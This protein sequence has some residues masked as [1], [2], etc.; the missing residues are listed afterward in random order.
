MHIGIVLEEG[1]ANC[2]L[3]SDGIIQGNIFLTTVTMELQQLFG[4]R[5]N[6]IPWYILSAGRGEDFEPITRCVTTA[7]KE[8]IEEWGEAIYLKDAI[9]ESD[10]NPL[11]KQICEV[12][13]KQEQNI[14][15]HRHHN[16]FK[17]LGKKD[18]I[19]L[20]ARVLMLDVLTK[21]YHPSNTLDIEMCA[22][23]MRKT[24]EYLFRHANSIGI[25]PDEFLDKNDTPN[26]TESMFFLSGR[27][28]NSVK[29][30][31]WD[32]ENDCP[33][34]LFNQSEHY[35]FNTV[36]SFTQKYSHTNEEKRSY[37]TKDFLSKELCFG[38]ALILCHLITAYGR[39]NDTHKDIK[40]IQEMWTK[41][42][43]RDD[44]SKKSGHYKR[45]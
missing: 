30:K 6:S 40:S 42:E 24:I 37:A 5:N 12:G 19:N 41:V 11:F 28:A 45:R 20:K 8:F 23:N 18:Y 22:N 44:N 29:L 21:L 38:I 27:P 36:L 16:S 31:L 15:L 26:L 17:Y 25:L 9:E 1:D 4:E 35:Q 39:F 10:E 3:R 7:R 32:A 13:A 43:D 33:F 14:V 2:K 34:S